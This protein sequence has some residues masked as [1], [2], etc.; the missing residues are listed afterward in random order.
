MAGKIHRYD[1]YDLRKFDPEEIGVF[2]DIGA[3]IGSTSIMARILNAAARIIALEPCIET[4][5]ILKRNLM[6][7]NVECYNVALGSGTPMCFLR[8]RSS[9]THRFVDED[10]RQWWP[11]EIDYVVESKTLSQIFQDYNVQTD[12][13]YIIKIDCEGGER[14]ILKDENAQ[15][16]IRGSIMTVM[17]IHSGFGGTHEQW[18]PWFKELENT[19]KLLLAGWERGEDYKKYVYMP[20]DVL[21]TRGYYQI[22]LMSKSWGI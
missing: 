9:G 20:C 14:H 22:Q 11:K 15:D 7:W 16:L 10:E 19:H 5:E 3:Q 21:P 13:P 12:K 4:F 1:C 6:Y 18:T 17:E 8:G 2:L